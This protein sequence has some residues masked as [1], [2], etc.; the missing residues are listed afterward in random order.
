MD[1]ERLGRL[2][3]R[4]L[5]PEA[6]MRYWRDEA[7]LAAYDDTFAQ[8][9]GW[10]WEAA[11]ETVRA[12]GFRPPE[13]PVLDFGCGSGVASR[14]WLRAFPAP[15][16]HLH[17]RDPVAV[18]FAERRAREAFPG[19]EVLR[20]IP[21]R[22]GVALL[23]HLIEELAPRERPPAALARAESFVWVE[24]GAR[25]ASRA[26]SAVRDAL[27]GAFRPVAPCRHSAPCGALAG[28]RDWCHFFAAAPPWIF[29]DREW[30]LF[31]R[32]MG[33]DL[34]SLPYSLLAMRKGPGEPEG[35]GA[36]VP[37]GRPRIEKARARVT[38]CEASGLRE[39]VVTRRDDPGE[40]ERLA[41]AR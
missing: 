27:L 31:G 30:V 5:E 24:S 14:V 26:L 17:D 12:R 9:I 1:W 25:A 40:W 23:S 28:D 20:G 37:L 3:A 29:H 6:G 18:A 2:R 22:P 19:L 4:F 10:K 16:L 34:R 8:R 11:I 32:R 38:L 33:I 35:A 21:E 41:G 39:R 15:A 7:D 36:P 13:G